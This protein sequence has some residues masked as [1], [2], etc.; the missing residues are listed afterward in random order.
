MKIE[1]LDIE[2]EDVSEFNDEAEQILTA[3]CEDLEAK[4]MTRPVDDEDKWW[5]EEEG[6]SFYWST[7]ASKLI[8]AEI[9]RLYSI[10]VKYFGRNNLDIDISSK[11]YREP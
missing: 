4:G 8:D 9:N 5:A 11:M 6:Y 10:A 1:E 7:E 3:F 2:V